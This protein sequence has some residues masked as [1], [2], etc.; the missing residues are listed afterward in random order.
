MATRRDIVKL[1]FGTAASLALGCG[2]K[3]S[4]D[5]AP[6]TGPRYWVQILLSGGAVVILL[7]VGTLRYGA[8]FFATSTARTP[9]ETGRS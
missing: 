2:R 8:A 1:A 5:P 4:P 7:L 9:G 3:R 6:D